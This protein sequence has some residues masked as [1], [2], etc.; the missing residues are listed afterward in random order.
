MKD[1]IIKI[2]L[3]KNKEIIEMKKKNTI[4]ILDKWIK[5]LQLYVINKIK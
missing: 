4:N 2:N 5:Y 3:N 1:W